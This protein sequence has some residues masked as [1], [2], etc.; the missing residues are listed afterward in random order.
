MG[1]DLAII[2]DIPSAIRTYTHKMNEIESF[3]RFFPRDYFPII[4]KL[5]RLKIP[6]ETNIDYYQE[7]DPISALKPNYQLYPFQQE[8][9]DCWL[10]SDKQGTII[11]P[12]GAGKTIVALEI[13][14][15]LWLTTLIVVP[16][17]VLIDQW[18]NRLETLLNLKDHKLLETEIIGVFG[19]GKQEVR[20]ITIITYDSAYLYSQRLRSQFGF[21]ILDE[22]H[23]LVG[24]N[25]ETIA[26]GYIAPFRLALTATLQPEEPAYNNLMIKGF[27]PILYQKRPEELQNL[28]VLS[29]F[30]INTI[31]VSSDDSEEYKKQIKVL[32]DYIKSRNLYNFDNPFRQIIFRV[33]QDPKAYEALQAYKIA[34]ELAFSADTKL[35]ELERLLRAHRD[36]KT[37]IFS[38]IVSFCERIARVFFLP[39]IT[40]RTPADERTYILDW[41]RRG[42]N[43][44]II[45]SKILDEGI[46]IPDAKIGIILAGSSQKRQFIQRLGRILRRYPEKDKAILYEIV[47]SETLEEKVA[48]KRKEAI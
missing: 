11:L 9:V 48:L 47:S 43:T 35:V 15:T 14:R 12:T 8:A 37:L 24:V 31:K 44:K 25:Y 19:G 40:H 17:L 39:C 41:Y 33:N 38:D 29:D 45:V 13:I 4:D 2:G 7:I 30:E 18:K 16:T 22:A 3:T 23:H 34:R 6:F 21:L 20:P 42:T 46:D 1:N 27:G 32:Q 28:E 26:D 10:S 36:D 5:S